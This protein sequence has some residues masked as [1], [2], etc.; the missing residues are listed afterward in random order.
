[1][2]IAVTLRPALLGLL[3]SRVNAA[4]IR[5][6]QASG[7][8][9]RRRLGARWVAGVTR[10]PVLAL[11]AGVA[12]LAAVA[13]PTASLQLGL[14]GSGS[15]TTERSDR[16]A[17]DLISEGFG[18]GANGVL[19]ALVE[20]PGTAAQGA[21]EQA[22]AAIGRLPGVAAVTPPSLS[23]TGQAALLTVVP[24]SGPADQAT[25]DLVAA[26]RNL[27]PQ[28]PRDVRTQYVMYGNRNSVRPT[29]CG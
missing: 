12:A 9:A 3:G 21:A 20:T 8:S 10:R 7:D 17:Y 15:A 25:T 22:A 6:A 19:L 24:T 11:V 4:R 13:L 29:N 27:P 5:P 18:P 26:I 23:D 1:M 28:R 16:R 2:L 14:P